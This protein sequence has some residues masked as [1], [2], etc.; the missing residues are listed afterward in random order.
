MPEAKKMTIKIVKIN[1]PMAKYFLSWG[2]GFLENQ[3]VYHNTNEII[4]WFNL[5]VGVTGG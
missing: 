4:N 3:P 5:R 1:K 2:M